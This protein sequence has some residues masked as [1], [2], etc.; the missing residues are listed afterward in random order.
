[1][2][3]K[4]RALIAMAAATTTLALA[5]ATASPASAA[6]KQSG[7]VLAVAEDPANPLTYRLVVT[8][9]IRMQQADAVGYINNIN[10]GRYPG[11][12]NYNIWGD[13]GSSLDHIFGRFYPG[14]GTDADGYLRATSEGLVYQRYLSIS[15]TKMNEDKDGAD[16][17]Y[18][19]A[20]FVDADGGTRVQYSQ[21]V[22]RRF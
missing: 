17:V 2:K 5:G 15:K 3:K 11:G 19:Q 6:P 18:A 12:M 22:V 14:A 10:T 16:E 13:D 21:L 4:A 7:A 20:V 9:I 1:M 8:G